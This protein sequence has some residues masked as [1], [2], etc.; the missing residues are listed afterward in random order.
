M[1]SGQ[2]GYHLVTHLMFLFKGAYEIRF[3]HRFGR[4]RDKNSEL[5]DQASIGEGMLIS[6]V[7]DVASY[8]VLHDSMNVLGGRSSS[9]SVI[10]GVYLVGSEVKSNACWYFKAMEEGV[11]PAFHAWN[12]I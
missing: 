6:G 7:E 9:T 3:S 10:E 11:N 2:S 1:E 4:K 12:V 5:W 8:A